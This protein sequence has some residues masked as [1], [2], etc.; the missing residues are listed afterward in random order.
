M[1][2]RWAEVRGLAE[3]HHGAFVYEQAKELRIDSGWLARAERDRL[4]GR[5]FRGAYGVFGLL[6]E[7]TAVAAAQLVQPR[8]IAG[9]TSAA[10]LHGFDGIDLVRAELLVPPNVRV[11]GMRTHHNHDLVVPEIVVVEG[12]RCTD[13]IRTLIDVASALSPDDLERAIESYR[14]RPG[15]DLERLRERAEALARP[16]RS[17]PSQLLDVLDRLPETP[18][19]SD[20]ETVY[21]QTL[22]HYGVELPV[23]QH[24]VGRYRLDL[25]YVDITLFIELD[26][27]AAHG[28]R[29][30]FIKDRH[31]QNE[32]VSLGWSPLRFTDSDVRRF[33]RRTAMQTAAEISRRRARLMSVVR[34]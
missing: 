10:L 25:A 9:F 33:G 28:S 22:R 34:V 31:R 7:W 23:R 32:L 1:D 17:G 26:G 8:A 27:F 16:G 4:I 5:L 3:E 19:D 14:R 12:L 20:L 18:T 11:R 30:A 15:A 13:E 21:W 2:D 24:R 6:D 29:D